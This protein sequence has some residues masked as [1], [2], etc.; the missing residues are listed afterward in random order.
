MFSGLWSSFVITQLI[1]NKQLPSPIPP[2][3][4]MTGGI[5]RKLSHEVGNFQPVNANFSLI[6]NP[7]KLRK[8]DRKEFYVREGIK[9]FKTWYET[10]LNSP[11]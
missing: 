8:K 9:A 10:Q 3:Q 5:L 2:E 11:K 1:E 4:T 7:N 6:N